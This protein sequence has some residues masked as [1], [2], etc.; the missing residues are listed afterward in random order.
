MT[1]RRPG[2]VTW[3]AAWTAAIALQMSAS[4]L[5]GADRAVGSATLLF[6]IVVLAASGCVIAAVA[7]LRRAWVDDTAELGIIAAFSFAVSA[8]PLVHGLTTPTVL[9]GA[10]GAT[11]TSVLWALPL[12]LAAA[13]PLLLPRSWSRRWSARWRPWVLIHVGAQSA[14][15]VA[16]LVEPELL[17]PVD[18]GEPLAIV[19]AIVTLAGTLALSARHLRLYWVAR[20][21]SALAVALSF[22]LIASGN[23]V[24][25]NGAPMTPAFWLAHVLDIVGVFGVTIV[26]VVTYRR[27]TIERLVFRP[28]TLR[29]PLDALELGLDPVVRAFVADLTRKDPITAEHVKRTAEAAIA[30]GEACGLTAG[31]LRELGL[32]AVLHDVGK[33][34][35]DD[36]VLNKA[37]RLTPDEYEHVKTHTIAGEQLVARSPVLSPIAPIVRHHHERVDGHGYPDRLA[38]DA[39]P[40]LA[41]IVSVCD[42]Y[43]AMVHTRQYR[44]GMAQEDVRRI[45]VEHAG[46]QWDASVVG[47]FLRVLDAGRITDEPTVLAE[48][49]NQIGCSCILDLPSPAFA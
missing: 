37:G 45:L 8:L 43:D 40:L 18:M 34:H 27:G 13:L 36:A 20:T 22:A 41:R 24:W 31:Q 30:V 19:I 14:L 17:R 47:T 44:V 5:P 32:G 48:L 12:A 35:I 29:D 21:P 9:Y 39:I 42:A 7:L 23:L 1:R 33:L 3:A 11:M 38:G 28:L 16:L 49:G 10:N 6:W 46:T 15:A 25:I 2:V 4:V 26:A